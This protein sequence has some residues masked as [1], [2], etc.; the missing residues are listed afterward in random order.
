[1]NNQ[2]Y[3]VIVG[4]I[5]KGYEIDNEEAFRTIRDIAMHEGILGGSS[6]GTLVAA[7]LKYCKEQT[8]KKNVVTFICDNSEKYLNTAYNDE[9]LKDKNIL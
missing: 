9:W 5:D 4:F 3:G 2:R 1:M 6:C 7:A 8:E